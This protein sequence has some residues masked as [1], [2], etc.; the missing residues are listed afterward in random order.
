[1]KHLLASATLPRSPLLRITV[2][3]ALMAGLAGCGGGAPLFT[4]DGRPTTRVQC[5]ESGG[6]NAC[7]Q[8]ATGICGGSFDTIQQ[9]VDNGVRSLLFACRPKSSD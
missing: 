1:M 5:P 7:M 3:I 9:S 8:N 6:W 4:P 2:S